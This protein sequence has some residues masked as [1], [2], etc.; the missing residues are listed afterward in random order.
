MN[1]NAPNTTPDPTP[2]PALSALLDQLAEQ[3]RRAIPDGLAERIAA[4]ALAA[5]AEP[6]APIP[7]PRLRRALPA[8]LAAALL[9]GAGLL[10]APSLT[11]TPAHPDPIAKNQSTESL[12]DELDSFLETLELVGFTETT[13]SDQAIADDFW[14]Y[15]TDGLTQDDLDALSL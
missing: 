14:D 8:A 2:D 15:S 6:P 3:D 12:G 5:H 11:T 9:L 1:T 10:I 4:A 7:F 13:T